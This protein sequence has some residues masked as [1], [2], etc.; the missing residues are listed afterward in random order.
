MADATELTQRLRRRERLNLFLAA[1]VVVLTSAALAGNVSG[2]SPAQDKAPSASAFHLVDDERNVLAALAPSRDGAELVIRNQ[3]GGARLKLSVDPDK[4][5][6][7][8]M[9][10]SGDTRIGVAQFAH[11]GGG[12]ALHSPETKGTA[13]LYYEERGS[14]A[15]YAEDGALLARVPKRRL[16]F[17]DK[18]VFQRVN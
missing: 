13:V 10:E 14:L 5:G 18:K 4:A 3:R 2:S 11:G 16:A 17:I 6:L 7:F 15:F 9:D 12:V 8:V 1:T